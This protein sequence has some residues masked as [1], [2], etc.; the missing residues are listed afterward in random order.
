[1]TADN[2]VLK[3]FVEMFICTHENGEFV[4]YH[5]VRRDISLFPDDPDKT[6]ADIMKELDMDFVHS[7]CLSHSTSWRYEPDQS[8][9]LTYLVWVSGENIKT[10]PTQTLD[11]E[12]V[13]MPT[14]A[15]PMA[16]RPLEL[17][18]EQVLIH[19]LRHL[20]YLFHKRRDPN[21]IK[22]LE[23]PGTA[24]FFKTLPLAVPGRLH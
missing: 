11:P 7:P 21:V 19:G 17:H 24:K 14:G 3:V 5:R 6:V 9:I 15:G 13:Q 8:L 12:T 1:M 4:R 16:P 18:E 2:N 10:L 22:A 23:E 20:S